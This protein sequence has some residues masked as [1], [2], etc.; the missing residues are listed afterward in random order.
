MALREDTYTWTFFSC[1]EVVVVSVGKRR[2]E[3]AAAVATTKAMVVNEPKTDCRR[4]RE[5]CMALG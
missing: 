1:T 4:F 3:R 2:T 5:E